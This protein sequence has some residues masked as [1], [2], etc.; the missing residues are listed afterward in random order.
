MMKLKYFIVILI[1]I[2]C[3]GCAKEYSNNKNEVDE[4]LN[5]IKVIINSKEYNMNLE[6]NNTVKEFIEMLPIKVNMAELNGNEKYYYMNGKLTNNPLSVKHINKGDVMLY[7]NN[8]IVI[9]YKSFDTT[10]SYTKIGHIDNLDDLGNS[11]VYV[12]FIK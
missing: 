11:D 10:Y 3:V 12:E 6:D 7:G 1:M 5:K 8:C 2:V 4:I 9:F